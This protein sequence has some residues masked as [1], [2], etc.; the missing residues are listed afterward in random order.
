MNLGLQQIM[1]SIKLSQILIIFSIFSASSSA[2]FRPPDDSAKDS[3]E[4]DAPWHPDWDKV[5]KCKR[6]DIHSRFPA[7]WCG[8]YAK[9]VEDDEVP[10]EEWETEGYHQKLRNNRIIFY[11]CLP[12]SSCPDGILMTGKCRQGQDTSCDLDRCMDPDHVFDRG[13]KA[14]VPNPKEP[15]E[16]TE[17]LSIINLDGPTSRPTEDV[18]Q[19]L[20]T[21]ELPREVP[22]QAKAWHQHPGVI[23]I[24]IVVSIVAIAIVNIILIVTVIHRKRGRY[25][26]LTRSPSNLSRASTQSGCTCMYH[27][28]TPV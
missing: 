21:V 3:E 2:V 28:E 23:V 14:C 6:G 24:V 26:T 15:V 16:H 25:R 13:K 12:C 22:S 7:C 20:M 5:V 1:K 17:G 4:S 10:E 8:Q 27:Y 9:I 19:P 11:V 18:P